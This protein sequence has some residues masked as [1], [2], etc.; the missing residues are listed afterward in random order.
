[1]ANKVKKAIEDSK[2]KRDFKHRSKRRQESSKKKNFRDKDQYIQRKRVKRDEFDQKKRPERDGGEAK[3]EEILGEEDKELEQEL[4]RDFDMG[5]EEGQFDE[6]EFL[7]HG[8]D[9]DLPESE[10]DE[11]EE[12]GEET[13]SELEE[14]YKELGIQD[15]ADFSK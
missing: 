11:E 10:S 5:N 2:R 12:E 4:A 8:D 9:L 7:K 6:Q 1:M 13:D 3:D 15:E 14:Y